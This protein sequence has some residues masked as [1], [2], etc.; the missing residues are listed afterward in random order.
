MFVGY[1]CVPYEKRI[2]LVFDVNRNHLCMYDE[3]NILT[4]S[5]QEHK[6]CT[7]VGSTYAK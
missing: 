2:F 3:D 6:Q 5:T 1:L 4:C 7:Y